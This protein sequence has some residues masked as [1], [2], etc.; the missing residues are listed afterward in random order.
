MNKEFKVYY[1][2]TPA[3]REQLDAIEEIVVEQEIGKA[4]EA[5]I[6]IPVYIA[7]DGSWKGEN[8][9]AYTEFARVRVEARIGESDFVPLIDGSIQSQQPDY[10]AS[11]GLSVVTL[12]VHDDTKMLHRQAESVSFSGQSD[13]QI[14]SSIFDTAA[15]GEDPD[16]DDLPARPDSNAVLNQHGTMM[17]MLRSIAARY[18]NYHAYV[19]PGTSVGTSKGCFKKLPTEP[20]AGLPTTFLSGPMQNITGFRIQRNSDQAARVQG[21]HLSMSDKSVTTASASPSPSDT[22][23]PGSASATTGEDADLRLRR[24]PPGIGDFTDLTEAANGMAE[25]SGFTLRAEGSV[26]PAIYGAILSPYKMVS[27]R[28]SNSRYSTGYVIFKVV[29]TLGISEYTQS[30]SVLGNAVSPVAGPS[31]STPEAAAILAVSFNVQMDIF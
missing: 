7:E 21:A 18:K 23:S 28:V 8:D 9:P 19:L 15:L 6:K 5:R 20:D 22:L 11:P 27:V 14:V 30:F 3:T 1:G 24:L 4:W 25:E 10:N 26:I 13:S 31:A 16:I 2:G 29:H 12:I 17:Q